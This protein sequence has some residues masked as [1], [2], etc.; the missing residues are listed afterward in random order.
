MRVFFFHLSSSLSAHYVSIF[1]APALCCQLSLLRYVTFLIAKYWLPLLYTITPCAIWAAI[2]PL[3]ANVCKIRTEE[4]FFCF[5]FCFLNSFTITLKF[6]NS[7]FTSDGQLDTVFS[8]VG[9]FNC[10]ILSYYTKLFFSST[11]RNVWNN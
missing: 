3:I 4:V 2:C 9:F 11:I 1:N 8:P 5:F 6:P 10:S 7:R